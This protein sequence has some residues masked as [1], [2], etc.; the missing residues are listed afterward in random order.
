MT[1]RSD[2]PYDADRNDPLT[3]LRIPVVATS[4][5]EWN[6]IVAFVTVDPSPYSWGSAERPTDL[7]AQQLASFLRYYIDTW[8]NESYK[9]RLAERPFDI[10]GGANGMTFIKYAAGDW[11]YRRRTWNIGPLFVPQ[12]PEF[13]ER[14][15]GPLTLPALFDYIYGDGEGNDRPGWARWKADHPDVFPAA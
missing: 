12:T 1:T 6:Y 15:I 4:H 5:P 11:G 10:D 3:K 2:W 8:Y 14:P 13:A 7:E 9:L